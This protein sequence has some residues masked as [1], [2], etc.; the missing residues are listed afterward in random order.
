MYKSVENRLLSYLTKE[1]KARFIT[2]IIVK[3]GSYYV[4]LYV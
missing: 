2:I 4:W 1:Y 3:R